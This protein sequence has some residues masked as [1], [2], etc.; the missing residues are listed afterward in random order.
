MVTR[1]EIPAVL[2]LL[3]EA[4]AAADRLED[5]AQVTEEAAGLAQ[6]QG[7]KGV[8]TSLDRRAKSYRAAME[9]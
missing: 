3:G 1:R 5:A 4:Y 6:A 9:P 2:A 7:S 8:H